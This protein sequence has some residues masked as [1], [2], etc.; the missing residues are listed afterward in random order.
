MP[1]ASLKRS[2]I[3]ALITSMVFYILF[4]L[5]KNPVI[6]G[7]SPFAEDPYDIMPSIAFQ[8]ALLAALLSLA[9]LAGIHDD[10]SLHQRGRLI[11][12]GILL[13]EMS[14]VATIITDGIA[15]VTNLPLVFSAPMAYL[16]SGLVLLIILAIAN[17]Y[18]LVKAWRDLQPVVYLQVENPLGIAIRDCWTLVATLAGWVT[19]PAAGLKSL[20]RQVDTLA[21][22]TGRT[23]QRK[24]PNVDPDCHP[25]RFAVLAAGMAGV[26]I[27][28][29]LIVG[30][31]L[32]PSF[33]V[34]VKVFLVF[35][36]IEMTAVLAGF[37]LFGRYLG[38]RP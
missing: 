19:R 9:R 28:V 5:S 32:P 20:W 10:L 4:Q 11:L 35:F 38:L 30:E 18:L 12:H 34:G 14:L 22:K 37:A 25:W 1:P 21:R 36:S 7:V 31:G 6:S 15:I 2:T 8:I 23:W 27:F 29:G 33:M 3:T 16:Y 17:G 24:L 26:L 13:V